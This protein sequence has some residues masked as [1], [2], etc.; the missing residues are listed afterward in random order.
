MLC[1]RGFRERRD[2]RLIE[3]CLGTLR[4]G[5][6]LADGFDFVTEKLDTHRPIGFGLDENAVAAI[7]KSTFAGAVKDGKPVPSVIDVAVN[8]RIYSKRTATGAP[9]S[10]EP[11]AG[12]SP[13]TGKPSMPGIYSQAQPKQQ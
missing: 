3:T 7:Q 13:V 12:A 10:A 11:V 4:L 5:I 6:E 2:L 9:E 8:F 1:H